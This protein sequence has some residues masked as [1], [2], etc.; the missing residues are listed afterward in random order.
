MI[1][2]FNNKI[3]KQHEIDV[4]MLHELMYIQAN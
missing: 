4:E 2:N 3:N 1:F